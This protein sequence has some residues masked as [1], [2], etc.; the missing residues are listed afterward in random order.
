MN[1]KN[2]G[3]VLTLLAAF[4]GVPSLA[5]AEEV[6]PAVY[7]LAKTIETWGKDPALVQAVV[8]QNNK[9]MSLDAIKKTDETWMATSGLDDV[10]KALLENAPAKRLHELEVTKSYFTEMFLMDNQGANVAMTNKTSDYWQGD[11]PKFTDSFA[12]GKGAVHIG[13]VKFDESAQ[14]YL[15]Q[16]SVPV[17]EHDQAIGALTVG[18]NIDKLESAK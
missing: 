11:E 14:S 5:C 17:M 15:V 12:S 13:K 2:T 3:A 7:E 10:M 6:P 16:V 1:M 4:I 9:G 8:A 18:V